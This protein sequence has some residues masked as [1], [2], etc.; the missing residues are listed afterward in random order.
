[1][2]LKTGLPVNKTHLTVEPIELTNRTAADGWNCQVS[3]WGKTEKVYEI[4]NMKYLIFK[5]I[6][7]T[8]LFTQSANVGQCQHNIQNNLF[9]I[10]FR[11]HT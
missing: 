2:F 9:H 10:L 3:G 8:G 11:Q 7:F 6:S 1:M 5:T 4:F